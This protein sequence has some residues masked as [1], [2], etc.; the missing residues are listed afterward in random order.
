MDHESAKV[1]EREKGASCLVL[2]GLGGGPYELE[3]LIAAL[4][5]A[6]IR[7]QAPV[8]PGH[9]GPGPLMPAS[10]WRDW[11][12]A[13]E[14][15]FDE[16]SSNGTEAVIVIGFSTGGTLALHLASR[17]PVARQVLLAPFLA[18]RHSGLI[19]LR[20]ATYLRPLAWVMP[21]LPRR[22]PAVRDPD[23][24]RWAAGTDRFRTFNVHA[25]ISA[26]ELIDTVKPLVPAITIPTLIIQGRLDS[27]VEPRGATWLHENLGA[28]E[29]TLVELQTSD[30][31]VALDR[32]RGRVIAL[33][34]DFIMASRDLIQI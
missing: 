15:A 29:K 33:V 13:S 4:K 27:V 8:L 19:P 17:R 18:I 7:V 20:P 5:S 1:E 11:A 23:Q 9:D 16:L 21:N 34:R 28:S 3:P 26:I 14:S 6:G 24:R 22:A 12:R 2:H 25:A 32:E 30:H 31:L 10:D